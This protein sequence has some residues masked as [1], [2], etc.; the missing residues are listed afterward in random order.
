MVSVV[1]GVSLLPEQGNLYKIRAKLSPEAPGIWMTGSFGEQ[2]LKALETA[3]RLLKAYYPRADKSS[4][5]ISVPTLMDGP[6]CGLPMFLAMYAVLLKKPINPRYAF[7]G[8]LCEDGTLVEVGGM[9]EKV[10]TARRGGL[11][12][13]VFPISKDPLKDAT[14]LLIC[15]V[16]TLDEAIT[17]ATL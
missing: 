12:G 2:S 8:E 16:R 11:K 1:T 17:I 3:I 5:N 7:T 15:P 9:D 14:G 13:I 6:S 4:I 10:A